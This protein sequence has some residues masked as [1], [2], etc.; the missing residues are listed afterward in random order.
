MLIISKL[1]HEKICH[2]AENAYP[3]ECCGLLL[4]ESEG[5]LKS[6]KSIWETE[7]AAE[8]KSNR[9]IIPPIELLK[10]ENFVRDCGWEVLGVYHSHP[11]HTAKPSKFD[12]EHAILFYSYLILRVTQGRAGE[13]KC[14]QLADWDSSFDPEEL[15]ISSQPL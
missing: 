9:Y 11:D 5:I 4:G 3:N 8:N 1:L 6:V 10:A 14:W 7:N 12:R 2:S 13:A 15:R